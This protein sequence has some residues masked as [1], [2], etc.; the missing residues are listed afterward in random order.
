M[1]EHDPFAAYRYGA[2]SDAH[3]SSSH[4]R[5][6]VEIVEWYGLPDDLLDIVFWTLT[7]E[8]EETDPMIVVL[9]RLQGLSRRMRAL[10]KRIGMLRLQLNERQWWAFS[11]AM[12]GDNIFLTGGAG[13]GKS[14]TLRIIRQY[15][16]KKSYVLCASTGCA[17]AL[18]G[19]QTFHQALALGEA[20]ESA[21]HMCQTVAR[22]RPRQSGLNNSHPLV[23]K[24][25][26]ILDEI[27]MLHSEVLDKA[28]AIATLLR[29]PEL[30]RQCIAAAEQATEW[31]P[32]LR[33]W[34]LWHQ[35][36]KRC[37]A[38]RTHGLQVIL[39]GDFFQLP[40]VNKN[41]P[42]SNDEAWAFASRSWRDLRLKN[43]VLSTCM[44]QDDA[45]FIDV[46]N[47]IRMGLGTTWD[48]QY[49]RSHCASGTIPANTLQLYAI[50]GPAD[51]TN[52]RM[53]AQL[54]RGGA[55]ALRV[56]S[57]DRCMR[58]VAGTNRYMNVDP[59][60]VDR[61][62]NNCMALRELL[63]CVGARVVCLKN[64][65][66]GTVFNGS[67]GTVVEIRTDGDDANSPTLVVVQFDALP[68]APATPGHRHTFRNDFIGYDVDDSEMWD[69][70]FVVDDQKGNR[71]VRMQMPLK[72][73]WAISIHKSQGMSL[74]SAHIDFAR[75]FAK[76]Q[77]YVALSR[78]RSLAGV[79]ISNLQLKHLNEQAV[80]RRV[81][82][83]YSEL[84]LPH[85]A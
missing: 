74:S 55:T 84:T 15:L 16:A 83:F 3:S 8:S 11:S 28:G 60:N 44:R 43:H 75:V 20:R 56:P 47:R 46:L 19:G 23:D 79:Y 85:D 36:A 24:S 45:E 50:N 31:Q 52:S 30:M 21:V 81:L 73:A 35:T 39:C 49:L 62:L 2:T 27:S 53:F 71:A 68:T 80:D 38:T 82:R 13:T 1:S 6:R 7:N 61:L 33:Q 77:A 59:T 10:Y 65:T 18:I 14:H 32:D 58:K 25:T 5:A 12:R 17:A 9:R 22:R 72:L 78:V 37:A 63:V 26:L 34:V 70:T 67:L 54:V 51:D 29:S 40:P 66:A 4:Q 48:L 76:G 42:V 69:Y 41:S 57:Y 64:V